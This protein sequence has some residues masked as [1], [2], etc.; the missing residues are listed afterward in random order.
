MLPFFIIVNIVNIVLGLLL[1][2]WGLVELIEP[3]ESLVPTFPMGL[4]M[5]PFCIGAGAFLLSWIMKLK[6]RTSQLRP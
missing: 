2:T 3:Q 4:F 6:R 5:G 1:T